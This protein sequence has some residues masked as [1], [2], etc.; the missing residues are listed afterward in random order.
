MQTEL[1]SNKSLAGQV[2][3]QMDM[4]EQKI[5]SVVGVISR[6]KDEKVE[7]LEERNALTE[8]VRQLEENLAGVDAE[9]MEDKL[10]TLREENELLHHERES[11]A[12]RIGELLDKLDL[13]ST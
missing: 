6:L 3:N 13:L 1:D 8:K 12:R 11:I 7:L 4:L 5:S 10:N 2:E 9:A